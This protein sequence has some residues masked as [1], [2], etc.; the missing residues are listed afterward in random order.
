MK[1]SRGGGGGRRGS[2]AGLGLGSRS[3][4]IERT[5]LSHSCGMAG[6]GVTV[7]ALLGKCHS[8]GKSSQAVS[9]L[10][11]SLESSGLAE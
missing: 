3:A 8:W 7:T 2:R 11:G 6:Q 9:S 10:K 4:G 5:G 1:V